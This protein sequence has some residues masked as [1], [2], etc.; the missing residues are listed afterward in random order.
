M[1]LGTVLTILILAA[2]GWAVPWA[3]MRVM[4]DSLRG[5]LAA[6]LIAIPALTLLGSGVFVVLYGKQLGT[7]GLGA[8]AGVGAVWHFWSLGVRAALIWGPILAITALALATGI[9][10]RR[11]ERMARRDSD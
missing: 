1:A 9:E 6:I 11:G 4:P 5:L 3:L 10:R 8:M 7:E 2:L